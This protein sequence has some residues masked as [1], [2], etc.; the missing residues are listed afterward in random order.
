MR[1]DMGGLPA[2]NQQQHAGM[3]H[4]CTARQAA[5]TAA[6]RPFAG[7]TAHR[8]GHGAWPQGSPCSARRSGSRSA[9]RAPGPCKCKGHSHS[10]AYRQ[11]RGDIVSSRGA[12]D[13]A[14]RNS[15]VTAHAP[16]PSYARANQLVCSGRLRT[17]PCFTHPTASSPASSSPGSDTHRM[18]S[19]KRWGTHRMAPTNSCSTRQKPRASW[20]TST[21]FRWPPSAWARAMGQTKR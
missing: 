3:L 5:R 4:A 13:L 12:T 9:S 16:N 1:Q 19:H 18:V 7:C 8:P 17:H 14:Q 10:K 21:G 20:G 15:R 6:G 11:N 2:R